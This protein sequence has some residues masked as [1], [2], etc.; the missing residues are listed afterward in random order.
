MN[1]RPS[2]KPLVTDGLRVGFC[3]ADTFRF[4][5]RPFPLLGKGAGW[6]ILEEASGRGTMASVRGTAPPPSD[7][8]NRPSVVE[9]DG[10]NARFLG[11]RFWCE[12]GIWLDFHK[13]RFTK[14]LLISLPPM[15][16][17][18]AERS[19]PCHRDPVRRSRGGRLAQFGT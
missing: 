12:S 2:N 15:A 11:Q 3:F 14:R 10:W 19:A 8:R 13:P 9:F 17:T 16:V 7:F 5:A 1:N 6:L 4:G 18:A